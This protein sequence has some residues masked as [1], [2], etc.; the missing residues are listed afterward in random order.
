MSLARRFV[1]R[2]SRLALSRP[3]RLT[4]CSMAKFCDSG[5]AMQSERRGVVS[6]QH[7][8]QEQFFPLFKVHPVLIKAFRLLYKVTLLPL[9]GL[10]ISGYG[11]F[12]R[13][14]EATTLCLLR[15]S[16]AWRRSCA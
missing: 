11:I 5:P 12:C 6:G 2:P 10:A 1:E 9:R 14:H 7:P 13:L 15:S 8:L 16:K 4:A 3:A